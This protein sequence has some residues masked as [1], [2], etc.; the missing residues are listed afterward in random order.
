[1][2][3]T[4]A[5]LALA[6]AG[7]SGSNNAPDAGHPDMSALS[8]LS[9]VDTA[10]ATTTFKYVSNMVTLPKSKTEYAAD[11][12]GDG[13][14]D[15]ALGS[16]VQTLNA[17]N[18]DLATQ[19]NMSIMSGN[20][21]V[22][23]SFASADPMLVNDPMASATI[24]EA[25]TIANPDFS[26]KGVFVA[27]KAVPAGTVTG[28]LTSGSFVSADPLTQTNPATVYIKIPL[29]TNTFVTLPVVGARFS[30]SP[31]TMALATGQLNGAIKQDDITK[32][33]IPALAQTFTMIAMEM[34]CD[35]TNPNCPTIEN[36]FDKGPACM[37]P[38]GTMSAPMDHKIDICEVA[39]SGLVMAL[40]APDVALFDPNGN[41][42]PDPT[43]GNKDSLSLGVAFTG[44]TAKFAN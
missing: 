33:L 6:V 28:P 25:D 1:M 5:F 29:Y 37:N 24:Y 8:D 19:E 43:N 23:I 31:S 42:K 11:L 44:V 20:G 35:N 39:N 38:D 10:R 15:N 34:P 32:T 16:I 18:V 22:L 26:G 4:Y 17:I 36:M 12:N 41:W 9:Y 14:P 13:K 40:L 27:D 3:T 2:K 30:F 21:L 7:C